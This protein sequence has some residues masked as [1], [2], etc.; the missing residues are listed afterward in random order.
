MRSP[1]YRKSHK[2][3]GSSKDRVTQSANGSHHTSRGDS[4]AAKPANSQP[5][6]S[7]SPDD[8][9]LFAQ[10]SELAE[11][12]GRA[13]LV[14]EFRRRA[15]QSLRRASSSERIRLAE[16]SRVE[17]ISETEAAGQEKGTRVESRSGAA[18]SSAR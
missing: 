7:T 1:A 15:E 14:E 9:A 10:L 13:D 5:S 16:E 3:N 6:E 17:P 2:Q 12:S 18:Q 4:H 11:R 8:P